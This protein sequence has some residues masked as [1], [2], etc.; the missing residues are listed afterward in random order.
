MPRSCVSTNELV[1]HLRVTFHYPA[2]ERACQNIAQTEPWPQ[3]NFRRALTM[4]YQDFL[5]GISWIPNRTLGSSVQAR[6]EN[7]LIRMDPHGKPF[8]ACGLRNLVGST[9]LSD[10]R[11]FLLSIS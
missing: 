2:G 8:E 1:G 11:R 6:F 4:V 7:G 9:T 10:W 3:R 5:P